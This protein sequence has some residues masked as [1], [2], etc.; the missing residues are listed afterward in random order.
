VLLVTS[1]ASFLGFLDVTIVNV[2]FRSISESFD[3]ASPAHLSWVLNSYNVLFA[4]FLLP[5]GVLADRFGSTPALIAGVAMFAVASALCS[6]APSLDL[7]VAARSLQALAAALV[8]PSSLAVL[9]GETAPSGRAATIALWSA[10]AA[11]A[12][13]IGPS[14][15]GLLVELDSW[16]LVFLVNVPVAIAL[17]IACRTLPSAAGNSAR[18]ADLMGGAAISVSLG[19]LALGIAKGEDWGWLSSANLACYAICAFALALFIRRTHRS[20]DPMLPSAL[21][22]SR[23]RSVANFATAVFAIAFY[24]G[25]L[26]NVL[27]L[28]GVWGYS[29]FEA[30]AAISP[31]PLTS[32]LVGAMAGRLAARVGSRPLALLGCAIYGGAGMGFLLAVTGESPDFLGAWLPAAILMGAGIGLVFAS[33]GASAAAS[34]PAAD[35]ASGSALN[36]VA[37]QLGAVIGTAVVFAILHDGLAVNGIDQYEPVWFACMCVSAGAALSALL[38]PRPRPVLT[39]TRRALVD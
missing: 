33:L 12:A 8:I 26:G 7:L 22:D 19:A 17:L 14:L 38:L 13:G 23:E 15:G 32:A 37:R 20:A 10:A 24:A 18:R 4:A 9:L 35:F 6:A 1:L 31:A 5:C 39:E 34:L 3:T 21:F 11:V 28:T 36:T 25:I 2:A 29:I 16:R 27:F 30:G